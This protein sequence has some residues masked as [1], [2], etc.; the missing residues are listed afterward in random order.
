MNVVLD[1]RWISET[2]SGI[3]F[4]TS[5]LIRALAA[6]EDAD[7]I[8]L[9]FHQPHLLERVMADTGAARAPWISAQ[10][11]KGSAESPLSQ[12][13]LP[14]LLRRLRTDVYHTPNYLL[15]LAAF[16]VH[17]TGRI[18]C[19]ATLHDLIPLRFPDFTPRA[20]KTRFHFLYRELLQACA[21]RIDLA[22]VP[23]LATQ[24][25]VQDCLG[26]P[27]HRI[28]VTPEAAGKAFS[29]DPS[30]RR[31]PG[32]ILYVGRADPYKNLSGLLTA[33]ARLRRE[34]RRVRLRIIGEPDPRYPEARARV[35]ELGLKEDVLWDGYATGQNLV[36]AYRRASVFVF[37]SFYEGFGLPV[38]EAMACG[39]PVVCSHRASL[40]EVAGDAALL[41]DPEDSDRLATAIGRV[42]SEPDLAAALSA[43]GMHRAAQFTW[44]R[45]ALQTRAAWMEAALLPPALPGIGNS[46]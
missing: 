8:I 38:L 36:S 30:V 13:V 1:A 19:V 16:P 28:R 24:R 29:P 44:A 31:E 21:A 26:L 39:T 45:T 34:G 23:S 37:P 10:L 41:I 17:R 43:K 40:P 4:Y 18:R 6:T 22:I 35:T 46:A 25:D 42:L 12:V 5:E 32:E 20:L 15:P 11:I 33:V 14:T 2:F 3:G 9:L 27:P 7:R